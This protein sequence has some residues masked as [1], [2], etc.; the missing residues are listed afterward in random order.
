LVRQQDAHILD[1][2]DQVILDLLSPE[3]KEELG[4]DLQGRVAQISS[5][6]KCCLFR[7]SDPF[8]KNKKAL[9]D[10]L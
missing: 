4:S 8:P 10:I 9:Q 2:C 5:N 7:G 1:G 3:P 6:E